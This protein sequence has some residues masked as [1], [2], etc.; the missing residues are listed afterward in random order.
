VLKI[1]RYWT[2]ITK[3][4][5]SLYLQ[6]AYLN[7]CKLGTCCGRVLN[8]CNITLYYCVFYGVIIVSACILYFKQSVYSRISYV[9]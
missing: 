2:S 8:L 7:L 5:L 4:E 9:F 6:I 3:T 1:F